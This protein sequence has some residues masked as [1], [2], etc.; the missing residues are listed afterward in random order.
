MAVKDL[1][2][3]VSSYLAPEGYSF[4]TTVYQASKPVLDSELNL[5]QDLGLDWSKKLRGVP[6][7]WLASDILTSSSQE[8]IFTASSEANEYEIPELR[9]VVN[10]WPILVRHTNDLGPSNKLDLG[11]GPAGDGARRTDL[12]I[13][14]V[15][16]KLIS[17]SPD[18]EGK[19]PSGRIWLNG[20]VK[21]ASGDDAALNLVDNILDTNVGAE[22]T[23]RVQIQYR[24]RVVQGVDLGL[25]P[26]GL[27]QVDARSTP[28]DA[29]TPDGDATTFTY[30]NQSSAGDPGLWIA[31]DGDPDNDLGTVDGFM[32]AL[33]VAAIFRR[34]TSA[35]DTD[36]NHNGGVA[37]PG[38]SDRPDGL[39]HDIVVAS[40]VL[41]LRPSISP[42]GWNYEELLSKNM[43]W[44]LDNTLSTEHTLTSLGGGVRGIVP[45]MADE[46]GPSDT[47]GAA[48]IGNFDGVR[49]RFSDRPVTEVVWLA[50]QPADG[51]GAGP[52]WQS[53]ADQIEVDPSALPIAGVGTINW[54][55]L[56]PA[57][58]AV[59]G[60][61][62]A[63]FVGSSG[64]DVTRP[65]QY[66]L[67]GAG[68]VPATS[69][70]LDVV[71]PAEVTDETL[72]IALF[73]E[74]PAGEGLTRTPT[75]FHSIEFEDPG[76]LPADYQSLEDEDVDAAH[77]EVRLTYRTTSK[78]FTWVVPTANQAQVWIPDHVAEISEV[79]INSVVHGAGAVPPA[80]R[81][82]PTVISGTAPTAGDVVEI[83]YEAIRPFPG[84]GE[85]AFIY[86]SARAPQ[87]VPD[88]FLSSTL[89]L[90]PRLASSKVYVLGCGS[91][92]LGECYPYPL[93]YV[94][95]GGVYPSSS[96]SY[97]GDHE[98]AYSTHVQIAG[99]SSESGFL[100][101]P[102]H[103]P[104]AAQPGELVLTRAPGDVD[105]EGRS[106][107]KGT[108]NSFHSPSAFGT[109]L[110]APQDH[111]VLFPV[112]CE[113]AEDEPW[114]PKGTLVLAL[115]S[116]LA[117]FD[118]G[119]F[120]GFNTDLAEN[121]TSVS[122]F[123]LKGHPLNC[124]I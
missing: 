103:I 64:G 86:Y 66:R 45:F 117:R 67:S 105:I 95:T 39:F 43:G 41:D 14:E 28:P 44:L 63:F 121:T 30:V 84:D 2:S 87:T 6:S 35:F 122:V 33:P 97:G 112:L 92:A 120:V 7:G 116:R 124:R 75:E 82:S 36:T 106:Y 5:A 57:G 72:Y 26:Y 48:L 123:N 54:A 109:E 118:S 18:T 98:L 101:V 89:P 59:V 94:Q 61:G 16:R 13:L 74:Y 12:V 56:A 83:D 8:A 111:R 70:T 10:N 119:N 11:A 115:F 29:L 31:G 107:Y 85:Q 53:S 102:V 46:I 19:S 73:V 90:I 42:Q 15:W 32:Y 71:V 21:I 38:P 110:S 23:K 4:E 69:L 91:S 104:F 25:D 77:R 108:S 3:N 93:Q 65:A 80:D 9:A 22:T 27:S 100:T 68:V 51:S 114:A 50:Y 55:S 52:N 78:T 40:D 37:S 17:A 20:N 24:L 88:G 81:V 1:G 60:A 62:A 58:V 96:S 34:N 49:R 99:F 79:R 47:G 76:N 113:V